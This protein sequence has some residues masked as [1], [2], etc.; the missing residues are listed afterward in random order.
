MKIKELKPPSFVNHMP[1]KVS[2]FSYWKA[3]ELKTFLLVCSLPILENIM[4]KK[5]FEHN[6][7]LVYAITVLI[8]SSVSDEMVETARRLLTEYVEIFQILYGIKKFGPFWTMTCF[9]FENFNGILKSYTMGRTI[10]NCKFVPL[11]THFHVYV[12]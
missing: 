9:Q 2:E 4:S 3:T 10:L 6:K 12:K 8:F 11:L 5:Y 7:L 1:R